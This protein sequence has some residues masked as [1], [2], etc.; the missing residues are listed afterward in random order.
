[1]IK[2]KYVGETGSRI[3][4]EVDDEELWFLGYGSLHKIHP[5]DI[6]K[7]VPEGEERRLGSK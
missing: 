1:M 7:L 3:V 6:P 4:F 2:L 5:R